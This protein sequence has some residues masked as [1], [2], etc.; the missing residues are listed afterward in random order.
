MNYREYKELLKK[1]DAK[2]KVKKL[3][4]LKDL[5]TTLAIIILEISPKIF[6]SIAK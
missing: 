6:Y 2:Q 3:Y 1:L 4:Y 5:K